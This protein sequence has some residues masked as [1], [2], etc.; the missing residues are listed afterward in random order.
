[1]SLEK[2]VVEDNIIAGNIYDK[3]NSSNPIV[4][5]LMKGYYANLQELTNITE[6]S[7]IHE[8]GCGEGFLTHIPHIKPK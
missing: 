8:V 3:Y 5:W 7:D 2:Y 1:M 4:K 6:S